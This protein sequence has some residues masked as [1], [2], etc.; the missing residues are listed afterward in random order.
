MFLKYCQ[1]NRD[2]VFKKLFKKNYL[3][4]GDGLFI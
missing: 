1:S 2:R 4:V 3:I